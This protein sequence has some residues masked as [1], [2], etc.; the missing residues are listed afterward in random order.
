MTNTP[1]PITLR[2]LREHLDATSADWAGTAPET[3]LLNLRARLNLCEQQGD[4]EHSVSLRKLAVLLGMSTA[5]VSQS[6]DRLAQAGWLHRCPTP[7]PDGTIRWMLT[8]GDKPTPDRS[9]GGYRRPVPPLV[10]PPV[11]RAR[12]T[13]TPE[14]RCLADRL[15]HRA[16]TLRAAAVADEDDPGLNIRDAVDLAAVQLGLQAPA[17]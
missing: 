8:R 17:D 3:D 6:N 9:R 4:L 5:G 1:A 16:D 10:P 13:L 12:R 7:A 15:H 2:A 11:P 14:Q